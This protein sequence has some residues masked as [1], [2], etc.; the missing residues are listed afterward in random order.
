MSEDNLVTIGEL[1]FVACLIAII[2]KRIGLPYIVGLVAAGLLIAVIPHTPTLPLSRDLIFNIFLPPLIFEAAI[3]LKWAKFKRELPVTLTFAL[4]GVAIAATTVA[5]G[6]HFLLGWSVLGAAL[7]GIL[8]S[9]TDPVSVIAA[10]REMKAEKRLAMVVESESLLNDAVVAVAFAVVAGIALGGSADMAVAIPKFFSTAVIGVVIGALVAALTM[11]LAYNTADGL[12]EIA[13]TTIAAFGSFLIAEH[14]HGSGVL[15]TLTAGL[16]FGNIGWNRVIE[17]DREVRVAWDFFAFVA[18]SFVFMLIGMN[19]AT[20]HV[21]DRGIVDLL[22]VI[23]LTLVGRAVAIY[24]LAQVFRPS[25]LRLSGAYQ[26]VLFWGGLRGALAL[27]LALAV[28]NTVEERDMILPAAFAVVA[29]SI[30]VQGLSMPPL[31]RGLGVSEGG[32]EPAAGAK[33]KARRK[34]KSEAA[35]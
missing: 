32:P 28:P 34:G 35:R 14:F 15:A 9:A 13:I 7:F 24:P 11:L 16:M 25:K 29:F 33:D 19:V 23:G 1:L 31:I 27:A 10:F 3:Q 17:G 8:I 20:Q 18:N 12:I 5:A 22:I 2:S 21:F 30:L 6:M 4:F 26:H